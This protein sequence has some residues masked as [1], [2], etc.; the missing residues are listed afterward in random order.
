MTQR[1][2]QEP[3]LLLWSTRPTVMLG[4]YQSAQNELNLPFIKQHQIEIVRRLSGGGTIYTDQGGCQ[5]TLIWPERGT[6]IDFSKGLQVITSAL[7]Q[8]GINAQTDSRND[9]VIDGRKVSGS[10]QYMMPGY[11]LHHGSLLFDSNL[12][13]MSHALRIDPL[14]AK[15]KQI[16]SVHQRTVNLREQQPSWTAAE[17]KARLLKALLKQTNAQTRSLSADDESALPSL[18]A[19]YF[20]E[21]K[22]LASASQ[23]F[24]HQHK[25]YLPGVGIISLSYSLDS[26]QKLSALSLDGDF[27]SNLNQQQFTA[28]LI[29]Q[30]YKASV[31]SPI[32]DQQLKQT[33]I[34][35]LKAQELTALLF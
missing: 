30:P 10:A 25:T 14:K 24:D 6:S 32:I 23:Q 2:P 5:F 16:K 13:W 29:G 21:D 35:G 15:A 1:K 27:F 12:D 26:D 8:I 4:K 33:P 7:Q 31:L 11:R 34:K 17:F 3:V 22:A 9:L 18:A 19:K 20:S 28:A